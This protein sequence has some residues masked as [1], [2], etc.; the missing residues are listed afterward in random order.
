MRRTYCD[1]AGGHDAFSSLETAPEEAATPS[2][3]RDGGV[4]TCRRRGGCV[5]TVRPDSTGHDDDDD[6]DVTNLVKQTFLQ[7]RRTQITSR[8]ID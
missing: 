4:V 7:P 6:D 2:S 3:Q 5:L 1:V 8:F